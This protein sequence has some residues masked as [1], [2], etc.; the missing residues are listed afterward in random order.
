M[1]NDKILQVKNLT[2][3][4]P[5]YGGIFSHVV[6]TVQAVND[7]T[8]SIKKGEIFGLVGESGCGKTTVGKTIINLVPPT[9][10]SVTYRGKEIFNV[11][12]KRSIST[13]EMRRLRKEMQIV[14]QD[15]YASLNPRMNVGS[16]ISEGIRKHKLFCGTD[17]LD[18]V[19]ELLEMCELPVNCIRKYPHE[20]SGGQ[21]QRIS[22]ARA[23]AV[24]PSFLIGDEPIAALDASVQAQI[25]I[26]LQRLIDQLSLTM[27]F[28][29]HDL[30]VVK[31]FCDNIAVMYL[32]SFV[33][34][35]T[36]KL[37]FTRPL[38]PY[39]QALLSSMPK[40]MPN[41]IKKKI[42]L[43]GEIPSPVNPPSGCR[44]HT[45]CIHA[46]LKCSEEKPELKEVEPNHYV[47][48]NLYS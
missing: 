8:F 46:S 33:E 22:I 35:A 5:I 10:G 45:R 37:L 38:H 30:G 28:I 7:V 25:L 9:G 34:T 48:C 39:S 21:R 3:H 14:F 15:P 20:F 43:E 47:A 27:L 13:Q 36:S 2:K 41:E 1:H 16:I 24:N 11:E 42:T 18:R 19:K 12:Q 29:S 40:N 26:L 31:Y 17:V 23:L 6:K 32:G 4:Y 44:F